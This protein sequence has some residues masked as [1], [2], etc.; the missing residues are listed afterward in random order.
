MD[1]FELNVPGLFTALLYLKVPSDGTM[2]VSAGDISLEVENDPLQSNPGMHAAIHDS[3]SG[4]WY[5]GDAEYNEKGINNM[6]A[7]SAQEWRLLNVASL[8]ANNTAYMAYDTNP[9][10]TPNLSAVDAIGVFV[11]QANRIR[12]RHLVVRE[13]SSPSPYDLWADSYGIYN[14]DAARTNDYDEDGFSNA[15]E[16][17][18]GGNPANAGGRGIRFN[19]YL[20][21]GGELVYIYPRLKS[22]N[23]PTYFLTESDSLTPTNFTNQEVSYTITSGGTWIDE[24][25]FEAVTN[26]IPTTAASKFI[27]LNIE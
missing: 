6:G 19:E 25:D 17:G 4:N 2:N 18:M 8:T 3:V 22:V 23:Q 5:V 10:V 24:P 14:A 20:T 11:N 12:F 13:G 26:V 1:Q 7:L 9:I 16:W 15:W 27:K 21:V